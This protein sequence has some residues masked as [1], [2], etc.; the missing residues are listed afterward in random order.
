MQ[1]NCIN[2][3]VIRMWDQLQDGLFTQVWKI[4]RDIIREVLSAP[5][6]YAA[7]LKET[8]QPVGSAGLM[9]GKTAILCFRRRKRRLDTGS[10]FPIGEGADP[11]GGL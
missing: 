7:V 11:G 6:T 8:G 1:K 4:S 2:T 5:E 3:Q 9:I 10:G